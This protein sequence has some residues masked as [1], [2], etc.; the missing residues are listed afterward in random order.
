MARKKKNKGNVSK[1]VGIAGILSIFV[2]GI[3]FGCNAYRKVLRW[4]QED[5]IQLS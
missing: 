3:V 2:A 1:V 4:Q 5:E